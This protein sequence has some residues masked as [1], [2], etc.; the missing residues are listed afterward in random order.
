MRIIHA[1]ELHQRKI[2]DLI[3]Q[4]IQ[5]GGLCVFPTETVYGIGAD[6][7]NDDAVKKIFMAKGRP[8]D[9][10]LIVH[11]ASKDDLLKC[12]R[13]VPVLAYPL[14]ASF[15]PGPLTL[16][17]KKNAL[18]SNLVTGGLDTVGVRIPSSMVA[19]EVI[20]A[21]G[22]P[23]CAPSANVSGRPSATLF[24]HVL[25]DFSEKVDLLVD[26]GKVVIG[27]ES[28]VL[29]VST[30][31]PVLLR[32][33]AITKAMIEDVL[34]LAIIDATKE[35]IEGIPKSPGMKYKHYAPRGELI[36]IKGSHDV[37][38]TYFS[39]RL[40]RDPELGIIA[41]TEYIEQ[42]SGQYL[43]SIGSSNDLVEIGSNLFSALR[44]M[45]SHD[46]KTILI[47]TFEDLDYGQ[48]IMNRL[49]KAAN[50][51]IITLD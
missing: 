51:K 9:N 11:L 28:T 44:W 47:P 14:M 29:D 17:F 36:L 50:Y 5:E 19:Q 40:K 13:E 48:A 41:P 37:V 32:P 42:L 46:V 38:L 43:V 33:G 4:T 18:I 24:S 3:K 34:G 31:T 26:G 45:D 39:E 25:D 6:A 12:V 21:A 30:K 1:R 16:V 8:S 27:I 10:P 49:L 2:K 15:W 35:H 22:V 23:L 20:Q 7:T